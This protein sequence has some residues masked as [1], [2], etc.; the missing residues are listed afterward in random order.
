M[1]AKAKRAR[2]RA[3]KWREDNPEWHAV[4]CYITKLRDRY[5]MTP[6]DHAVMLFESR[7]HCTLCGKRKKLYIDHCHETGR[8]RGLLC[9]KCNL[10]LAGYELML[11]L[12]VEEYLK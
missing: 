9:N 8:V 12:N 3:A 10:A 11:K 1:S 6:E 4:N 2:E 7:G 5:G